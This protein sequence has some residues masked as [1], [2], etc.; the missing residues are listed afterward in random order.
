MNP[1]LLEIFFPDYKPPHEI[2]RQTYD[3]LFESIRPVAPEVSASAWKA[4]N[5]DRPVGPALANAIR[6]WGEKIR[7]EERE[8]QKKL[9]A[10]IQTQ[11]K[12]LAQQ[13]KDIQAAKRVLDE[14]NKELAGIQE[15]CIQ[16][17]KTI[18]DQNNLIVKKHDQLARL[19]GLPKDE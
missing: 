11:E 9:D 2:V 12:Q 15:I 16:K 13:A 18:D 1:I 19:S 7:A 3:H 4:W 8:T 6:A 17:Q 14:T 5:E 10:L